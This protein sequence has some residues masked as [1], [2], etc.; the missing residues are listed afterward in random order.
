MFSRQSTLLRAGL[1]QVC[2]D[3]PTPVAVR[4]Q[5]HEEAASF[6]SAWSVVRRECRRH[7]LVPSWS[8]ARAT[9]ERSVRVPRG[10]CSAGLKPQNS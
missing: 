7:V 6:Q 5:P 9:L 2:P 10:F 1:P 3:V 8:L 4:P